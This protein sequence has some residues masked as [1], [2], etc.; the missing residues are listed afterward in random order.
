MPRPRSA[1]VDA[2]IAAAAIDLLRE[3]GYAKLTMGEV[4]KRA[5]V[6]KDSLYRRWSS[7]AALVHEVVF[8]RYPSGYGG[9]PATGS[10]LGDVEALTAMLQEANTTPEAVAAIPGLLGERGRDPALEARLQ[11]RWYKPMRAG[12]A[13]VLDAAHARGEATV[14]VAPDLVADVLVGTMLFRINLM[15]VEADA[16]FARQLAE[17]VVRALTPPAPSL[18]MATSRPGKSP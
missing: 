7:K 18:A 14:P 17:F 15:R 12:F 13:A 5:G 1:G 3:V 2:S 11:E 9:A 4:A 6:G 8:E 16:S 10:L